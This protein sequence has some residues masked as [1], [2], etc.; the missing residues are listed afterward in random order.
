MDAKAPHAQQN[1]LDRF[2]LRNFIEELID[3][4]QL[5]IRDERVDLADVATI[6]QGNEKAVWFRNIGGEGVEL[7]GN[8]V[9]GRERLA[10]AF[11]VKASELR[12]ELERRLKLKP[13]FIELARADAPVQ[14]IVITGDDIDVTKLPVHLQHAADGAPF[15]SATID[16]TIDPETGLTNAGL[17]RLIGQ[18]SRV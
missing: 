13:E 7:V 12:Q 6:L 18:P 17:R 2:R 4:D 1:D 3:T 11:G 5:D 10:R 15:I 16:Y 14:E 8:V 9:G